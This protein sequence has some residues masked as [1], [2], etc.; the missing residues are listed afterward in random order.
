MDDDLNTPLALA[1]L[2]EFAREC[3]SAIDA[4]K[5]GKKSAKDA[6]DFLKKA[7]SVL[8]VMDF[9]QK[10]GV[11]GEI[12]ALIKKRETMRSEKKWAEADAIRKSLEE[13]GIILDDTPQGTRWKDIK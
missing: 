12:L 10:K 4:G 6:L 13:K 2:F 1:A 11:S 3:N 8:A 5:I 7:D 9:G